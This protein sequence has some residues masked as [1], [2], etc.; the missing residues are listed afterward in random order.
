[1]QRN[2][3][4][5]MTVNCAWEVDPNDARVKTCKREGCTNRIVSDHAPERCY[6]A[7][8]SPTIAPPMVKRALNF[9]RAALG[10]AP[11]VGAALVHWDSSEAF[12]EPDEVQAIAAICR[13]CPLLVDG[14][15]T[16]HEC[17]CPVNSDRNKFMSKLAWK[18]ERCPD[19]RW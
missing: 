12:R 16:H 19:G 11:L 8:E 6:A 17:G 18:S 14:V 1:M 9:V 2:G 4:L 13:A 5:L 3:D 7:C 10:Q 15:C